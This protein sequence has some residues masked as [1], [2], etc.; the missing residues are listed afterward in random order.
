M[1]SNWHALRHDGVRLHERRRAVDP[2]GRFLELPGQ[3]HF[4]MFN[5][6]TRPDG[7]LVQEALRLANVD[8]RL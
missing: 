1:T 6:L 3:N 5:E 8:P 4:T 7:A 2:A